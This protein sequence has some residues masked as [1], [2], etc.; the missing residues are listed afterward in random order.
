MKKRSMTRAFSAAVATVLISSG[1]LV[2]AAATANAEPTPP[3]NKDLVGCLLELKLAECLT[4]DSD[5]LGTGVVGEP[6]TLVEPVFGLLPGTCWA[7]SQPTSPGSVTGSR[8]PAPRGS[9]SS[10]RP[11]LWRAARSP[12]KR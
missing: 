5:L 10:S 8:S 7:C 3:E 2:G 12:C 9:P 6:L 4:S 1:L 11:R